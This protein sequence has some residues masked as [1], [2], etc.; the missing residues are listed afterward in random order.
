[1]VEI[2]THNG[3]D[4]PRLDAKRALLKAPQAALTAA[5]GLS[6][7]TGGAAVLSTNDAAILNAAITR[8]GELETKLRNLGL[9]R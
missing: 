9:L 1:M 2:H 7:S 3:T 8:I 6:L 5:S 4:S